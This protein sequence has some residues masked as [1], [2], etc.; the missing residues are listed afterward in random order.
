MAQRAKKKA[1]RP[2][3]RAPQTTQTSLDE[4]PKAS[5][6]SENRLE[7]LQRER[8]EAR[9]LL[10]AAEQRIKELES[11]Q[12]QVVNRIDWVIDSLHNLKQDGS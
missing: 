3:R 12:D 5:T 1:A 8:D 7:K 10:A 9:R 11:T 2:P 4:P 6:A